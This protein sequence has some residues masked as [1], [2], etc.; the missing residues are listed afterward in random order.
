M[1][2]HKQLYQY[3]NDVVSILKLD[4]EVAKA[5]SYQERFK[6]W[7]LDGHLQRYYPEDDMM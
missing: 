2:L 4:D 1:E 5:I 3:M 7:R 6:L